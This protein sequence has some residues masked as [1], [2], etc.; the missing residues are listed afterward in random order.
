[1]GLVP[2]PGKT[3]SWEASYRQMKIMLVSIGTRGDMEPFLA[4]GA[5]LKRE[6]HDIA[7]AMPEQFRPLAQECGFRFHSLGSEFVALLESDT[8]K[9]ALGG[10]ASF[11]GKL[12]AYARLARNF[13][14]INR[15]MVQRQQDALAREQPD[16]T[17]HHSKAFYPLL[18][19]LDH[20]GK[21]ILLSPVPYVLH[22]AADRSHVAFNRDWGPGLNRLSYRLARYGLVKS[23][24]KAARQLPGQPVPKAAEIRR[25]L[26]INPTVYTISPSLF[27][28]PED[29]P[30]HYQVLGFYERDKTVSWRPP[31]ELP[32]FL[33]RHPKFL[34]VTFGSMS[35]PQPEEKTRVVVKTLQDLHIPAIINCAG[36]GLV[37]P[38]EYNRELLLFVPGIPYEYIFPKAY[39]VVHHGG[40]GTV[41]MALKSGCASLIIPHIIDQFLWNRLLH[42]RGVGPRGTAVTQLNEKNFRD[43]VTEL[44]ENPAYREEAEK[45]SRSMQQEDFREALLR[46]ILG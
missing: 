34:V 21:A 10:K 19:S 7:C 25:T 6:G 9:V 3:V 4:V 40:S 2:E 17:V 1:M 32:D 45:I 42:K 22:A 41:H 23:I 5:L 11:F 31:P 46:A 15:D 33:A 8:G 26:Q 30:A 20:P 28:R 12:R 36:G 18:W 14:K 13:Q 29:W 39:A 35:N 37:A 43:G 24:L 16:R 27:R 44:W 38:E